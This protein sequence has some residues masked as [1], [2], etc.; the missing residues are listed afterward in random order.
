LV[1]LL[2]NLFQR[3]RIIYQF[4]SPSSS[5]IEGPLRPLPSIDFIGRPPS[6]VR[7]PFQPHLTRRF[8]VNEA[9][10]ET[11]PTGFQHDRGVQDDQTD[12]RV[13]LCR[14]NLFSDSSF[15]PRKRQLFQC[16]PLA[17][18]IRKDDP[19]HTPSLDLSIV[20]KNPH[21]PALN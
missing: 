11:V 9:I 20:T 12:T 8:H 19:G 3:A 1:D 10:A 13:S 21:T 17:R 16:F 15:D 4:V 18:I 5:L 14:G 7:Q 6:L 2:G